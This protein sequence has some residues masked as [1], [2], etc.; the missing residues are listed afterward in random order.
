[1]KCIMPRAMEAGVLSEAEGL[2]EAEVVAIEVVDN[3]IGVT[4]EITMLKE[5]LGTQVVL[6]VDI[7]IQGVDAQFKHNIKN[8]STFHS[9][10]SKKPFA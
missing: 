7:E 6:V 1:M 8:F 5:R 4:E 10:N 9:L 3:I 2:S